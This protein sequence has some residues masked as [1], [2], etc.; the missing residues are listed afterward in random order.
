MKKVLVITY[1]WP[2]AGGPGVQR[3]LKFVKY[4]P[5]FGWQPL[6]LTV[7]KGAYPAVDPSLT[8]D[9]P[10]ECIVHQTASYEPTL[11][12]KKFV[13]M[14]EDQPIPNAVVTEE[15]QNWKKKLA[16]KIRL[17]LFIPDAKITWWASAVNTGR[18]ILRAHQPALIF[19]SSPPPTVHLIAKTLQRESGLPWVTDFRDPWTDMYY[20]DKVQK[21]SW[22]ARLDKQLEAGVLQKS[23]RIITVSSQLKHLLGNKI[24]SAKR[25][26]IVPNG[27][28][29]EDMAAIT[30][31]QP[32]EKFTLAY[33]G[34][35]N[36]QQNP[37]NL[38][39]ALQRLMR[40]KPGFS[41]R[42]RLLFMGQFSADVEQSIKKHGLD[43][44]VHYTGYLAHD[45]VLRN[46]SKS[47]ALLLVV[48]QAKDNK[49]ILTGKVFE[50]L[51]IRRFIL[52]IG[53]KDGDLAA[54]LRQTASGSV[55]DFND[56]P[57]PF[58][59]KLYDQWA[60][61][62]QALRTS[63]DISAYS[64]QAQTAELASLFHQLTEARGV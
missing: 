17:N 5:Q 21:S 16:A 61:T 23:D 57:Q 8:K 46:L 14:A 13:G 20:Y 36:S 30:E 52:A 53:P 24:G 64:R 59:E 19:S 12:Y 37:E 29:E 54:I 55:Y 6:V 51:G 50:Y 15:N 60:E 41:E 9:I 38:W 7:R 40:A 4:L 1:Y 43:S 10:K 32:F 39:R 34:K 63:G 62:Q 28:D 26:Q 58:I 27:F 18:K 31:S 25:I 47:H 2:P 49:G 45:Q 22:A 44:V 48:P 11:L 42:F 35:L 33:A 3:V 56:R